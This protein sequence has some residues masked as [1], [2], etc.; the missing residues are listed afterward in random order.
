M[1]S[2]LVFGLVEGLPPVVP[3]HQ[4]E[5]WEETLDE[6]CAFRECLCQQTFNDGDDG[7]GRVRM[8]WVLALL[9][10]SQEVHPERLAGHARDLM[11][12]SST[13]TRIRLDFG[14]DYRPSC[15]PWPL[16]TVLVGEG[17]GKKAGVQAQKKVR[18]SEVHNCYLKVSMG[19]DDPKDPNSHRYE[20]V[21]RIVAWMVFGPPPEQVMLGGKPFRRIECFHV[22]NYKRCANPLH[23]AWGTSRHNQLAN[24]EAYEEALGCMGGGR[25]VVAVGGRDAPV[26]RRAPPKVLPP[27]SPLKKMKVV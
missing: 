19:Y 1:I 17:E 15:V 13:T 8:A 14:M 20:Y 3:D 27:S 24:P 21:H 22:C 6:W 25:I 11:E 5:A 9:H 23:L 18:G 12:G 7:V 10:P 16:S 4:Y 2:E 26:L